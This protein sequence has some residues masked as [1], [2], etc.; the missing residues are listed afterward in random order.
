MSNSNYM[1][2]CLFMIC[3]FYFEVKGCVTENFKKFVENSGLK[4][5]GQCPLELYPWQ[6]YTPTL[7]TTEFAAL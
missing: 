3:V 7:A 4:I 6:N 5:K 2:V 1:Y